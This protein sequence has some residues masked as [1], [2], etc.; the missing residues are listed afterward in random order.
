MVPQTRYYSSIDPDFRDKQHYRRLR[1]SSIVLEEKL[2]VCS[3]DLCSSSMPSRS[4]RCRSLCRLANGP[5]TK[6]G[7]LAP[8][9]REMYTDAFTIPWAQFRHPYLNPPLNLIS[10]CLRELFKRIYHRSQW[11]CIGVPVCFGSPPS[12]H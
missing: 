6:I 9:P 10:R 4:K 8:R 1:I 5:I 11:S 12:N 2:D 7:V 3:L